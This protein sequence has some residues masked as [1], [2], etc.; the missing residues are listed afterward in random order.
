MA[1]ESLGTVTLLKFDGPFLVRKEEKKTLKVIK[2][3]LF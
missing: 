1:K 2:L 3:G